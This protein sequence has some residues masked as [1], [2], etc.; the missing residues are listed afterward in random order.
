MPSVCPDRRRSWFH[1]I[2]LH[3]SHE[4]TPHPQHH[5]QNPHVHHQHSSHHGHHH[6]VSHGRHKSALYTIT[7][8][9][10]LTHAT[11]SLS[12][13]DFD[14]ELLRDAATAALHHGHV[15]EASCP[16]YY[17]DVTEHVPKRRVFTSPTSRRAIAQHTRMYQDLFDHTLA[18]LR[19]PETHACAI[20]ANEV[21]RLFFEFLF[22]GVDNVCDSLLA[23]PEEAASSPCHRSS[24]SSSSSSC[25][26]LSS[27]G[28]SNSRRLGRRQ[29]SNDGGATTSDCELCSMGF[30]SGGDTALPC[31]HV[32]HDECLITALNERLE[33]P[34]CASSLD[35]LTHRME[36]AIATTC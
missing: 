1:Q 11:L 19:H 8:R 17:V 6:T 23:V 16:W 27:S 15:C 24:T 36:P 26:S 4:P 30:A 12:K 25:S 18:F 31:G 14:F 35:R 5:H 34:T 22:D 28:R 33:C 13:S 29:H 7:V 9:H 2:S 3:V 21:P 32:F 20:A 10:N